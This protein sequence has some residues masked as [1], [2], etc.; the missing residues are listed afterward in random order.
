MIAETLEIFPS[1]IF[2]IKDF[3]NADEQQLFHDILDNIK[4]TGSN[5][6][7]SGVY[8]RDHRKDF[9]T[10]KLDFFYTKTKDLVQQYYNL[11]VDIYEARYNH[12]SI[13]DS[14]LFH[15][16]MNLTDW[17][18]PNLKSFCLLTGCY[19]TNSGQ[20]FAKLRFNNPQLLS[21][22]IG[23]PSSVNIEPEPNSFILFPSW[24]L[25]GTTSHDS[26]VTRKCLVMEMTLK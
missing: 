19:Y 25:H 14:L 2:I 15:H 12:M 10:D 3:L 20:G 8:L 13:G 6:R 17:D 23:E 22:F 21:R 5:I 16:H 24:I 11:D 7:N 1:K 9:V 26:D 4:A 18:K